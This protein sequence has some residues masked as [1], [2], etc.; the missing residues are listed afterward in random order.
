LFRFLKKHFTKLCPAVCG[1]LRGLA[2]APT[3]W[4]RPWLAKALNT[5][6]AWSSRAVPAHEVPGRDQHF[7]DLLPSWPSAYHWESRSSARGSQP[8]VLPR[9]YGAYACT[10]MHEVSGHHLL[11]PDGPLLQLDHQGLSLAGQPIEA[12][13]SSPWTISWQNIA[14]ERAPSHWASGSVTFSTDRH[15]AIGSVCGAPGQ[16]ETWSLRRSRIVGGPGAISLF[17]MKRRETAC[18]KAARL[19]PF[20][21]TNRQSYSTPLASKALPIRPDQVV[22]TNWHE[23][24]KP[25]KYALVLVSLVRTSQYLV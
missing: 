2:A 7:L 11:R 23:V 16:P 13:W 10:R 17:S 24:F 19:L 6:C 21:P 5:G 12:T 4:R 8:K 22:A 25:G 20:A 18:P 15:T 9:L 1:G 14:I 3:P